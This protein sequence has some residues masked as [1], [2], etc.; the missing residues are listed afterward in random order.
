M[1]ASDKIM[2]CTG[3]VDDRCVVDLIPKGCNPAAAMAIVA[4]LGQA[5][6]DAAAKLAGGGEGGGGTTTGGGGASKDGSSLLSLSTST[7]GGRVKGNGVNEGRRWCRTVRR[8]LFLGEIG[9]QSVLPP[10]GG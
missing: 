8:L 1:T 4:D 2:L 3:C 10:G 7:N 5:A 9:R 6:A